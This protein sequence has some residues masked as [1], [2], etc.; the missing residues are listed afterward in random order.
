MITE[1]SI[2]QN[3]MPWAKGHLIAATACLG[4]EFA[5]SINAGDFQKARDFISW[6]KTQ[7]G[8][9]DFYIELNAKHKQTK[10]RRRKEYDDLYA[11]K[12]YP[13]ENE[14][15]YNAALRELREETGYIA[16]EWTD[17]GFFYPAAAYSD[18]KITLYMAR[19]LHLGER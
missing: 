18:E 3:M 5:S 15:S 7:F 4:G 10:D 8:N 14:S 17:L 9:D 16:D 1:A 13:E 12:Q 6:C 11:K 19:G 2:G